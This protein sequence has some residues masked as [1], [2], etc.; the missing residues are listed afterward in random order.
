MFHL[1]S[2]NQKGNKS[3]VGGTGSRGKHIYSVREGQEYTFMVGGKVLVLNDMHL[4]MKRGTQVA[5]AFPF[6][7][8]EVTPDFI[9]RH[10]ADFVMTEARLCIRL[11]AAH[12]HN[13][14]VRLV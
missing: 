14:H 4:H 1:S 9:R 12:T 3:M 7:S 5:A 11:K 10:L 2:Q 13:P 6:P 8:T